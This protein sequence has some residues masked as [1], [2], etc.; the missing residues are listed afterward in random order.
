MLVAALCLS[1]AAAPTADA[2]AASSPITAAVVVGGVSA[3]AGAV[4]AAVMIPTVQAIYDADNTTSEALLFG[5][6]A[7]AA[8]PPAALGGIASLLYVDGAD[9]LWIAGGGLVGGAAGVVVGAMLFFLVGPFLADPG[10]F[11]QVVGYGAPALGAAVGTTLTTYLI[12]E[13]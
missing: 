10:P 9:A 13:E 12:L 11:I 5:A 6:Y 4:Y 8:L 1:L 3:A 2:N 7:G